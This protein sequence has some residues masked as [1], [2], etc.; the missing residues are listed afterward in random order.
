[1]ERVQAIRG[2][3]WSRAEGEKRFI[4]LHEEAARDVDAALAW[5]KRRPEVDPNRIVMS[6]VSF[7]GIQ[8]V[9]A[10]ER[11]QGVRA[12]VSFAPGAISWSKVPALGQRLRRAAIAARA[13]LLVVQAANDFDLAPSR[14]LG[15]ALAGRA[16]KSGAR[17]FPAF[18]THPEDGHGGFARTPGGIAIWGPD[19]MAFFKQALATGGATPTPTP[20]PA[21]PAAPARA[22]H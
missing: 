18:G 14:E 1:L 12:F 22:A 8:T 4:A 10:A 6:G 11:G 13:P 17:T 5:L 16:D 9:L 21:P 20:T 3:V 15:Q 7:G 19:V 2:E